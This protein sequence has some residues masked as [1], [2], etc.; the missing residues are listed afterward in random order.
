MD[1]SGSKKEKEKEKRK[2]EVEID[3]SNIHQIDSFLYEVCP[4]ICKIFFLNKIGT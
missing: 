4:S 1:S 2:D 3:G